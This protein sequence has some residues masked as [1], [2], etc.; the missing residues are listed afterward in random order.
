MDLFE[1]HYDLSKPEAGFEDWSSQTISG[2]SV[3]F[4]V[5]AAFRMPALRLHFIIN[6]DL[7]QSFMNPYE[8]REPLVRYGIYEQEL[9]S[10]RAVH[11]SA[12]FHPKQEPCLVTKNGGFSTFTHVGTSSVPFREYVST[13]TSLQI[14]AGTETGRVE[15]DDIWGRHFVQNVRSTIFEYPPIPPPLRNFVMTTT[16]EVLD[17]QGNRMLGGW[18]S[19]ENVDVHVQM[20]LLNNYPKWFEVTACKQNRVLQSCTT[21]GKSCGKARIYDTDNN[22]V[23]PAGEDDGRLY[24]KRGQNA[25]YGVCFVDGTVRLEGKT[26]TVE[27][28][29]GI[30]DMTLCAKEFDNTNHSCEYAH[31][32]L[33]VLKRCPDGSSVNGSAWNYADRV[34]EYWPENYIK[35]NMWDL[36]HY[37]YDDNQFDKAYKYHMDNNLPHLEHSN[38]RP[39]N[40]ISFPLFKGLG[41][42]MVYDKTYWN[43]RFGS[44]YRG[45]WSDNLQNRDHT[46]VAGNK[47]SNDISVGQKSLIP[48]SEWIDVTQLRDAEDL[49]ARSEKNVYSCL[50]N[51]RSVK[52]YVSNTKV[53]ELFNVFENNVVPVP[54]DFDNTMEFN[55]KCTRDVY[56]SP[57][58]IS[59]YPNTVYTDTP[60]DWLYFGANLRGGA[61]EDINVLYQLSPLSSD[62]I[63]YEGTAK[64]QDGGRFVYWN[65]AN[66]KN[67]YLVVDNPVH[68]IPAKRNDIEI[69]Q[70]LIPTYTTTFDSVVFQHFTISDPEEIEREWESPIWT[71]NYGYGDFTVQVY[72]GDAG[73]TALPN[74]GKTIR[75]RFTF[76][77]NAGFD[78]NMVKEAMNSTEV[79]QESLNAYEIMSHIVRTLRRP[80]SYNFLEFQVPD[81]IKDYIRIYPCPDVV[82]I[83]GLF[84]DFDSIN[85]V[86]IRDGWKGDYYVNV[87]I[88]KDFP[89]EYRGRLIEIPVKLVREYFDRLP[90]AGDATGAHDYTIEVPS[91]VF[92]VPYSNKHPLWTGKVF[93]TSGYATDVIPRVSLVKPFNPDKAIIV[94]DEDLELY[95]KCLGKET[96]P[97]QNV[98]EGEFACLDRLWNE[99]LKNHTIC[100]YASEG[101]ASNTQSVSFAPCMKKNAPEFPVKVAAVDGPD[102]AV[103]HILMR[104]H[105]SQVKSGYPKVSQSTTCEYKDWMNKTLKSP[106]LPSATVHAKGAWISLKWSVSL[107]SSSGMELSDPLISP[108]NNGLAQ[109]TI[110]LENTG[111]YYAYNVLFNLTLAADVRVADEN[112][113]DTAAGAPM[114]AGCGITKTV[115]GHTM[116]WCDVNSVLVPRTPQSYRFRVFYEADKR[117]GAGPEAKSPLNMR[118]LADSSS[119]SIDLTAS[120]GEKRVTQD[121]EG[122]YGIPYTK[123]S[124]D[125]MV[126]LSG[127]RSSEYGLT[128]SASHHLANITTY[129][130]RAKLPGSKQWTTIAVTHGKELKEYVSERFDALGGK[131]EVAVDYLV[132]VSRTKNEVTVEES[133][134]VAILTQSNVYEWRVSYSN[135]LL[136]LLLLPGLAIPALIGA[137]IFATTKGVNKEPVRELGMAPKQKFVPQELVDDEPVPMVETDVSA[138]PPTLPQ[139]AAPA[140]VPPEPAPQAATPGKAYAIPTGPTYLRAGVPVNVVDN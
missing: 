73:T 49:V 112:D 78:I 11:G 138:P 19:N 85:V 109:V 105:A 61:L 140:Y 12:E 93:Y 115:F 95:R 120:A 28:M 75:A 127:K 48:D 21:T 30:I 47:V 83:A 14:P 24:F 63:K 110:T 64:V 2:Q 134:M 137:G 3:T 34:L 31:P 8:L 98:T 94:S 60:R 15:W 69:A 22:F 116:F 29:Q 92:G 18:R 42:S 100:K 136:L 122:P 102:Q 13:G 79:G 101:A 38:T 4:T 86:T 71:N 51:R 66:S 131:G 77:N 96:D 26:L 35:E 16:F 119:A 40:L 133:D 135:L 99:H 50:F 53:T 20:K 84:F 23:D 103:M 10:H 58:N 128:L 5:Q 36:T 33:P 43:K 52:N 132:A 76:M 125:N 68:V 81:Y 9:L 123:R 57:T 72:V 56:Y 27:D 117:E 129:I 25:S 74:P 124:D 7:E 55:Y 97:A 59:Q 44:S 37:D 114:P 41:Y 88:S 91:L 70:E 62:V 104:T 54:I 111:D 107:L 139:R 67:S 106:A 39:D 126:V 113:T 1:M 90:G 87:E 6:D 118:I 89:D 121:L 80:D 65:P 46:L 130:W 17:K 45:W 108:N 32:G 82:G